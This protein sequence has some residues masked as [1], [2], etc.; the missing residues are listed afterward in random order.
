[1]GLGWGGILRGLCKTTTSTLIRIG[2]LIKNQLVHLYKTQKQ[3]KLIYVFR[4]KDS[5]I[6]CGDGDSD[7]KGTDN[8]LCF[9]IW[10]LFSEDS[11]HSTLLICA[12]LESFFLFNNESGKFTGIIKQCCWLLDP[13][14][15][16]GWWPLVLFFKIF[17]FYNCNYKFTV[18]WKRQNKEVPCNIHPVSLSGYILCNYVIIPKPGNE[19][20]YNV[21]V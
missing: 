3:S 20:G 11:T 13:L 16:T 1:M 14:V 9:L 19:R 18:S 15:W 5:D 8:A 4:S 7:G 6:P 21:C 12:L 2:I 17:Y 10:V